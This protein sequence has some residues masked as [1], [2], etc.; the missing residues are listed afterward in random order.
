M[1]NLVFRSN[2]ALFLDHTEDIH[3]LVKEFIIPFNFLPTNI[4]SNVGDSR[5]GLLESSLFNS[6]YTEV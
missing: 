3:F 6:Y 5:W 2:V 1:Q 4:L